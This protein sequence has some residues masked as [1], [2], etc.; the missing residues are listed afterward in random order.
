MKNR[1]YYSYTDPLTAHMLTKLI[2]LVF[3]SK[4]RLIEF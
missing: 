2:Q 4:K 1:D 3:L